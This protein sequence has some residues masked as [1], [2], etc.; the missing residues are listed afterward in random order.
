MNDLNKLHYSDYFDEFMFNEDCTGL[1]S[2]ASVQ[3]IPA[4]HYYVGPSP[5]I[6]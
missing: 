5:S 6:K 1:Q 2:T 4:K 3:Y